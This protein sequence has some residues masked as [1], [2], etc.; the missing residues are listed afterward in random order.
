MPDPTTTLIE[1]ADQLRALAGNGL[2]FTDDPH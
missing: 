1:I 2:R